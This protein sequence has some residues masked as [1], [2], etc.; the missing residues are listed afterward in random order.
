[1]ATTAAIIG[2]TGLLASTGLSLGLGGK[3]GDAPQVEGRFS[4]VPGFGIRE[5]ELAGK[6]LWNAIT[7]SQQ[8][9][10]RFGDMLDQ[11]IP[12]L[13]E[14]QNFMRSQVR[15]FMAAQQDAFG[16]NAFLESAES[17]LRGD[18][19]FKD[20]ILE[21]D[22]AERERIQRETLLRQFGPGEAGSTAGIQTR[23]LFAE[24]ADRARFGARE[25]ALQTRGTL[26]LGKRE[27]DLQGLLSAFGLL[28][29][30]LNFPGQLAGL[31]QQRGNLQQPI[32]A[33]LLSELGILTGG[34]NATAIANAQLQQRQAELAALRAQALGGAIGTATGQLASGF[35]SRP[36]STNTANQTM[37]QR[38]AAFREFDLGP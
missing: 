16:D 29:N 2:A 3:G 9:L 22:I 33:N 24:A 26:G 38:E 28:G 30:T 4:G 12:I 20:P 25:Q 17:I 6:K 5:T 34:G 13:Q 19:E 27:L 36:V 15:D 11:L 8:D 1:M 37:A 31:G 23:A 7:I 10:A 35:R 18:E 21:R 32:I 14:D